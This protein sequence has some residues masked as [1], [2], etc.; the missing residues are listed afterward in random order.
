MNIVD[1]NVEAPNDNDGNRNPRDAN[2]DNLEAPNDNDGNENPHD[3]N[4]DNLEA[5]NDNDGNEN[6]HD[7]NADNLEAL[8]DNEIVNLQPEIEEAIINNE[9]N[10]IREPDF[11]IGEEIATFENDTLK[12]SYRRVKFKNY[13]RFNVTD[14]NFSLKIDFKK[15]YQD[16][17]MT[18]VLDGYLDGL[19]QIF[20]RVKRDFR[21]NLDRNMYVTFFHKDLVS[22]IVVGPLN[23][24]NDTVE[25]MIEKCETKIHLVL[26]SHTSLSSSHTLFISIRLLGDRHMQS[27]RLR[28]RKLDD[29]QHIP[30]EGNG[31]GNAEETEET[32]EEKQ[33]Y[34]IKLPTNEFPSF[35]KNCLVV[36]IILGA[37]LE[38][39]FILK[40]DKFRYKGF[41]MSKI[42]SI[43]EKKRQKAC[44]VLKKE[45]DF[46]KQKLP[47]LNKLKENT[48]ANTCQLL[49]Q[50]FKVNI[51]IHELQKGDDYIDSIY[52]PKK[53]EYDVEFAR[54]DLLAERV[55]DKL[56]GHCEVIHPKYSDYI[57]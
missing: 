37:F 43:S 35:E 13:Q 11:I 28:Q 27:L 17:L 49:A 4:A 45:F 2:A 29:L 16:V 33:N 23:F 7:A 36:S 52:S 53:R 55:G 54:V 15:K 20:E 34:L 50:Y 40:E 48:L 22:P 9:D 25:K 41:Q 57:G 8:N 51:V 12:L 19:R 10:I 26:T 46:V 6:R 47:Q 1:D 14:Y 21:H 3:A 39:G 56:T 32:K 18:T 31:N 38:L 44:E 30:M 42:T 24:K 5:L